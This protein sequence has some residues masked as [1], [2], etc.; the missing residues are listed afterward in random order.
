MPAARVLGFGEPERNPV[1]K[2]KGRRPNK[3]QPPF[4]ESPEWIPG[5]SSSVFGGEAAFGEGA[6][7]PRAGSTPNTDAAP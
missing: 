6:L 1:P 3:R 2:L 7:S 5:R 4:W